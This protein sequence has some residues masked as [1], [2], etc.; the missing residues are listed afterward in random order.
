VRWLVVGP[1]PPEQ[2]SG[3]AAAS[4]FVADRLASGDTVHAV[5]PRPTAAHDHRPLDGL[6]AIWGLARSARTERADGLWVRLEPGIL[7][8]HGTSR[9]RALVERAALALLLRRFTT[10]VV[11]VGDVGLLP[12]GRAGRPVLAAATR[13]VTHS[14]QA[15][16][17][18]LANGAPAAKVTQA[19][20]APAPVGQGPAAAPMGPVHYPE[21]TALRGLTGDRAAIEAA[22]RARA[23]QLAAARAAAAA[24][25]G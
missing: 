5:S 6:P 14:E 23:E 25:D 3:P 12:G 19:D 10:S 24:A 21:A 11:D 16:A 4:A 22:V 7:L 8:R 20:D 9:G 15:T 2:G 13:F 1:Y 18:L 17:T